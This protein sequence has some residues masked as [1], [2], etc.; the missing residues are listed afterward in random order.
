MTASLFAANY[1][2]KHISD[3]EVIFTTP[4]MGAD[5]CLVEQGISHIDA[6]YG[7]EDFTAFTVCRKKDGKYYIFGKLWHKHIDDV[8]AEIIGYHRQFLCGK[9]YC[10]TNADKGY[11]AKDLRNKG[12]SHVINYH[13]DT[14]KY[15]KITSYLKAVWK[16]VIFVSGTDEAY[17]NQICDYNENAEHDD[18]PDSAASIVRTLWKKGETEYKPVFM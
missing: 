8:E 2:L 14:N 13:E 15:F 10:E 5:P 6:A 12:V 16:D 4:E 7:G 17:I 3:E 18:A 1:E 9:M 11:L